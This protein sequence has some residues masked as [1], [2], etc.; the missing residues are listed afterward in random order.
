MF[1][2]GKKSGTIT[3]SFLAQGNVRDVQVAGSFTRWQPVAMKRCKDGHFSAT[4]SVPAGSHEYKFVVDGNWMT[5]PDNATY[6]LNPYG[7]AN[8]IAQAA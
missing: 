5:D 1:V 6:V 4:V 8:S 2:K 3:F 7:T